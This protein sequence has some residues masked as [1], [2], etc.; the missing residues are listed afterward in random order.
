MSRLRFTL[1]QLICVVILIGFGF[2]ALRN[3]D[4]S[5][6]SA[7]FSLAILAVSVALA[8]A[9]SRRDGA[10]M[11][12]AGFGIA[13]GLSLLTWLSNSH[14]GGPPEPFLYRLQ[15]YIN[16]RVEI[17]AYMQI[18][19]SLNVV[20]FGCLGAIIGRLLAPKDGQHN[21]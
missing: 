7:T 10:R 1:A 5:W 21:V 6:S 12:W 3:A 2:A 19:Q 20:L 15:Q 14:P 16:P 4:E 9:C 13:G 17:I 18:S 11:P 8:G